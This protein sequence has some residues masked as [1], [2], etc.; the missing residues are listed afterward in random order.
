MR[1]LEGFLGGPSTFRSALP[2]HNRKHDETATLLSSGSRA[3]M[4]IP[5][6]IAPFSYHPT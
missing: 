3:D 6:F 2:E 4:D 1:K 5:Q